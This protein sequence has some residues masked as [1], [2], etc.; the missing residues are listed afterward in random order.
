MRLKTAAFFLVLLMSSYSFAS[1]GNKN[2]LDGMTLLSF[3]HYIAK[4]L[5]QT[6][7]ISP[8][9][10]TNKKVTIFTPA[11]GSDNKLQE[12]FLNVLKMHGYGAVAVNGIV[13]IVRSRRMRSM[14]VP[15]YGPRD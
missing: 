3:I 14:P 13:G 7:I 8:R 6:V 4:R 2:H 12:V 11:S 9:V 10:L 5:D 15:V 1:E